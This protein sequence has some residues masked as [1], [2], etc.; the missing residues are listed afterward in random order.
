M[1]HA[2]ARA[3][4]G[5]LRTFERDGMPTSP[6]LTNRPNAHNRANIHVVYRQKLQRTAM[7]RLENRL[8]TYHEQVEKEGT[9]TRQ[10][11]G[12]H[13]QRSVHARRGGAGHR[14]GGMMHGQTRVLYSRGGAHDARNSA[15]YISKQPSC[16]CL[17]SSV[18]TN[19]NIGSC[20][21]MTRQPARAR[22]R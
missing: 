10:S 6:I 4:V 12:A 1:L 20:R 7:S 3:L 22:I 16:W 15:R 17:N 11:R 8:F 14:G 19:L 21:R 18:Y 13:T 2:R 5:V 9:R